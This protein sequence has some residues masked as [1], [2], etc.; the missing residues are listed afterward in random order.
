MWTIYFKIINNMKYFII[1]FIFI[2]TGCKQPSQSFIIENTTNYSLEIRGYK[3]T[4]NVSDTLNIGSNEVFNV[5]RIRGEVSDEARFFNFNYGPDSVRIEFNNERF[6]VLDCR[7]S[8]NN[9]PPAKDWCQTCITN[10]IGISG[11]YVII[12]E[13]H[14]NSAIPF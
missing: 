2:F 8:T 5:S 9:C 12:T 1:L 13:E 4:E 14:Y 11:D 3:T 10:L 6:L 7:A